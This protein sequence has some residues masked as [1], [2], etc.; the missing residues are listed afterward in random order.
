MCFQLRD[1]MR[2]GSIVL[3]NEFFSTTKSEKETLMQLE[4]ELR[5]FTVLVE[6][7]K[8]PFGKMKRTVCATRPCTSNMRL[9]CYVCV[10]S[11]HRQNKWS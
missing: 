5:N 9:T 4:D 11:V 7:A 3:C 1:A 2:V 10:C 6:A 8:T